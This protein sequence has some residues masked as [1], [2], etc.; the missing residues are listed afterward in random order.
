M[1]CLDFQ[2]LL[3]VNGMGT[4]DH[5]DVPSIAQK[6]LVCVNRLGQERLG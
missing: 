3:A 2:F 6:I 4:W 5:M 1:H